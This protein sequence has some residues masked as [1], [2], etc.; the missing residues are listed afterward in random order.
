MA[1]I[2]RLPPPPAEPVRSPAVTVRGETEALVDGRIDARVHVPA[3]PK[4]AVVLCH[5]HPLYGGSM[6]SP[7]P[8][9]IA[10]TL[11]D[12]ASDVV[13]WARFDFRGVGRSTGTHDDGRGEVDDARAVIEHLRAL[14]PGVPLSVCG[15][16]FGSWVGLRAAAADGRVD[17]V[18][19]VGPSVRFF[20]SWDDAL[21]FSGPKTIFLGDEDE[22]C[23]VE[24]GRALARRLGAE[25]R[26]FEGF[27]HH[28]MKSRRTM[29]MAAIPVIAP[30]V[31][32]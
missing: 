16:S 5:P 13:A 28:F 24:E 17:R 1:R 11:A 6:N 29:A 9:A 20:G 31:S 19:L 8:L 23:D 27:D 26:V 10:K 7:V 30:E 21:S 4:R 2:E 12:V 14:A 18:L 22:Y 25:L 3:T 15:H 32:P